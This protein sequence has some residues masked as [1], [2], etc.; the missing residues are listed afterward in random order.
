MNGSGGKDGIEM[1]ME[2]L[3]HNIP[4][5]TWKERKGGVDFFFLCLN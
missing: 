2:G 5:G 4:K 1:E 3:T